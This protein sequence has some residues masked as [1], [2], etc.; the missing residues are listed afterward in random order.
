MRILTVTHDYPFTL[1]SGVAIYCQ[2]L[3]LELAG[4]GHDVYHLFS[5]ERSWRMTPHLRW[6]VERGITFASLVN[7]PLPPALSPEHPLEDCIHPQVER[8]F[9]ACLAR[10]RPDLVH[11]HA[12]PGLCGSVLP[13]VKRHGLPVILTLHD[14][15][16]LCPRIVLVRV[17]GTPCPGPDGGRNCARFCAN[18]GSLRRRLYRRLMAV[19]PPG[20]ALKLVERARTRLMRSNPWAAPDRQGG[21]NG[22][23][24]LPNMIAHGARATFLLKMLQ[25][26]D[27]VL[28][29]SNFVKEMFVRN[30]MAEDGIQVLRLGLSLAGTLQHRVRQ[31]H[32]PLRVGYLGRVVHLKGAHIL[33]RAGREIP[34]NRLRVLFF[35]PVGRDAASALQM[36]AGRRLEFRGPYARADLPRILDEVD[37]IVVP[38]LFQETVGLATLE[39]HAAGLPVI[40]SRIGA[41]P[42]YIQDG[43]N[44]LLFE[45]GNPQAL[46]A[47][48]VR[49]LDTPQLVAAISA[50]TARPMTIARHVDLLTDIY[51][52]CLQGGHRSPAHVTCFV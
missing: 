1:G 22:P 31:A 24:S 6:S 46:R 9:A 17:D 40:A 30:G 49:L 48:L 50:S 37:V 45:P 33:A 38:T 16:A 34:P 52:A 2:D 12:F 3:E 14:F 18:H 20:P 26:A 25:E 27:A 10:A 36:L 4:R 11:I 19:M 51:R 13:L 43:G 29:V 32:A 21:A 8:L 41:I 39:A 44:G 42:E 15:W 47:C 23:G 28:A 7:S 35:G 5:S